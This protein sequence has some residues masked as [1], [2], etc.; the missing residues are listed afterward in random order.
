MFRD[1]SR[2]GMLVK[3]ADLVLEKM[4]LN[5]FNI[6]GHGGHLGHTTMTI[7]TNFRSSNLKNLCI[8]CGF[9]GP[10]SFAADDI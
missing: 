2:N 3:L 9:N 6:Y 7:C 5:G 4:I 10:S 1:R 8:E